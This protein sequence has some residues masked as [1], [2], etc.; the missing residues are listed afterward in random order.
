MNDMQNVTEFEDFMT[1][2]IEV[3]PDNRHEIIKVL[4]RYIIDIDKICDLVESINVID[5]ISANKIL[6]LSADVKNIEDRIE[7][8]RKK[9]IEPCRK[10]IQT[11]NDCAKKLQEALENI[12]A[13]IKVKLL[14]YQK[15]QENKALEAQESVKGLSETLGI[16]ISIL[17]PGSQKNLSSAK[18]ATSYRETTTFIVEDANLIPDEYW[19]IDERA[20]QKHIDM[21]KRDIPG[22]KIITEKT[23]ILRRK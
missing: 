5:D 10:I 18:A 16:D 14:G 22:V 19:K 11:I 13:T 9:S 4:D 23:M 3:I 17:T 7:D 20:I 8:Y 21:G 6:D 15:M 2:Q 1:D 12:E